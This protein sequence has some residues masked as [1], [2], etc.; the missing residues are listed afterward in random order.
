MRIVAMEALYPKPNLSHPAPGREIHPYL[1]RS[2]PILRPNQVRSTDTI[3]KFPAERE[4][5]EP[6]DRYGPG[7]ASSHASE[8]ICED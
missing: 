8:C 2:V 3:G 5:A 1:L 7:E 4:P 6:C